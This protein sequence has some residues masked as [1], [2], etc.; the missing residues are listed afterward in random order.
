MMITPFLNL[1]EFSHKNRTT[2]QQSQNPINNDKLTGPQPHDIQKQVGG[3]KP[4]KVKRPVWR[5]HLCGRD[6][7]ASDTSENTRLPES[8]Q[9][10]RGKLNRVI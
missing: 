5:Q 2:G 7:G 3:D 6:T 1:T 10:L 4:L 8:Q 9:T